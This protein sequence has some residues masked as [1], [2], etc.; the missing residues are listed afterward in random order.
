MVSQPVLTLPML[1]ALLEQSDDRPYDGLDEAVEAVGRANPDWHPEDVLV[2]AR[3]LVEV[4]PD[5]ARAILLENGDWDGGLAS[6]QRAVA[7]GVDA[8]VVR[9][10]PATGSL[11]PDAALPAFQAL[12]GTDHVITIPGAAHTPQRMKPGETSETPTPFGSRSVRRA[13]AKPRR[14]NLVAQ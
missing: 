5:A 4:D 7:S 13:R 9:G 6:L 3:A 10:D 2:K 11:L 8:W 12:L 14:P 1:A